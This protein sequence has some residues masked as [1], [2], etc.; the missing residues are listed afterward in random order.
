MEKIAV[1]V[2]GGTGEATSS[3]PALP[4][5]GLL[6]CVVDD[7]DPR[8]VA[9]WVAYPASY[10]PVPVPDGPSFADS[11]AAGVA[12][13]RAAV[14]HIDGPWA[15]IGYSQ[16]CVVIREMLA[17]NASR[18]PV[19]I[20]LVADPHQ[21][22][23]CVRGCDGHGVAGP[24]RPLPDVPTMWIGDRA[25]VICNASPDSLVRDIADLTRT[26]TTTHPGSWVTMMLRAVRTG[27]LQNARATS[28]RPA[29][30]R[31]DV[32]RLAVAAREI[33]GY[34][35]CT[36]RIGPLTLPNPTG[37]RHVAYASDRSDDAAGLTGC[38]ALAAWLQ[39]IA[40]AHL[41][42][43]AAVEPGDTLPAAFSPS[44]S[45]RHARQ[46]GLGETG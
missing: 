34:L 43:I 10:G 45:A 14:S 42:P 38:A 39:V 16:G 32:T 8:F 28:F 20:G 46:A 18:P 36:L 26:L 1:F 22:A 37:G 9:R 2:V 35:P 5:R 27:A 6:R 21:P 11:V 3:D 33:R 41:G 12:S 44:S 31:R 19:A 30:W 13:L 15:A 24:G 40:T 23:G 4:V 25:D 7:L 17:D 29:Q